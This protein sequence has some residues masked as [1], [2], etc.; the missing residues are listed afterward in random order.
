MIVLISDGKANVFAG[1][2]LDE[3]MQRLAAL[4]P[5][6]ISYVFVNTENRNRSPGILEN[7]ARA[8]GAAHFYLEELL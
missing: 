6:G 2:S 5:A 3:D 7:M 4:N 1:G 8:L